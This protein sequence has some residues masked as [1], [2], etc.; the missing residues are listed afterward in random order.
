MGKKINQWIIGLGAAGSGCIPSFLPFAQKTCT[1]SCGSCGAICIPGIL[2]GSWLIVSYLHRR[3]K[4]WIN[5][6]PSK[7]VCHEQ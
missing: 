1:G 6:K 3:I 2:V 5:G 7:D 4:E